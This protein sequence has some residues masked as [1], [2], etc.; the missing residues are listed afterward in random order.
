M[1]ETT[2]GV[3]GTGLMGRPMVEQLLAAG[4]RVVIAARTAAA[5]DPLVAA[6]AT[7]AA[8]VAE[9]AASADSVVLALP[10]GTEVASVLD[11]LLDAPGRRVELVV[12]TSTIHPD[13][14]RRCHRL[15]AGH[16][17]AVVDAPVSGGPIAVAERTLSV[18]AGGEEPALSRAEAV[19]APFTGRFVRCGGPGAGQ[20]A[21][22]CNQLV[23]AASI[24]VVAE[25]LVLA[26][27]A[28][29]D[30]ASV[31]QA[32]LGGYAASR[33][34]ELHGG[35]ML[36]GDFVPGGKARLQLKDIGIVRSLAD[37]LGLP[38]TAFDAAAARFDALVAG[39]HGDLDQTAV[40]TVLEDLAGVRV[41]PA[42]PA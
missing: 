10:S 33:V 3:V 30:P 40:V 25:A 2:I 6:G 42:D 27:A 29:V 32:L 37:A 36:A 9:L 4:C 22:A 15:A 21:K 13:E 16:G 24:E 19:L 17:V 14:A 23:V 26:R 11:Q 20:V 35:R 5:A 38:L 39:G 1:T 12:D 28:G 31:R 7:R 34:L 41:R 8:S 18:M